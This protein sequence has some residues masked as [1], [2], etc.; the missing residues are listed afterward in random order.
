MPTNSLVICPKCGTR[1]QLR[2][3]KKS[4]NG[5]EIRTFHCL[6]CGIATDYE[7]RGRLVREVSAKTKSGPAEPAT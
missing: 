7:I 3:M 4:L 1:R 6:A 2:E 5:A